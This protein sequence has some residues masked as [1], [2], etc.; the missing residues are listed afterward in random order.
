[1]LMKMDTKLFRDLY[2]ANI[3][4]IEAIERLSIDHNMLDNG[5]YLA[6]KDK[7]NKLSIDLDRD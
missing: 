5:Y 6:W 3:D 7:L 2:Q 4:E 1:M